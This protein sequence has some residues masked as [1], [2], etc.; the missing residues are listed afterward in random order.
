MQS[1]TICNRHCRYVQANTYLFGVNPPRGV[2]LV[3]EVF[4]IDIVDLVDV[5]IPRQ[6]FLMALQSKF[7][8]ARPP[9]L[10]PPTHEIPGPLD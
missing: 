8:R 2:V 5:D 4:R 10:T 1:S 3:T 7:R 6:F 9:P